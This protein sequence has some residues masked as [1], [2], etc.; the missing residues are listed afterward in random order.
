MGRYIGLPDL[1]LSIIQNAQYPIFLCTHFKVIIQN[2]REAFHVLSASQLLCFSSVFPCY[3]HEVAVSPRT[4]THPVEALS[5]PQSPAPST[6]LTTASAMISVNAMQHLAEVWSKGMLISFS[7]ARL[8]HLPQRSP[9]SG[10][11]PGSIFKT[12]KGAR[13]SCKTTA[14]TLHSAHLPT[15]SLPPRATSSVAEG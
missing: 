6:E 13:S 7:S 14:R 11:V 3:H 5:L 1:L 15:S 10:I 2:R 4:V 8:S 12:S 9:E